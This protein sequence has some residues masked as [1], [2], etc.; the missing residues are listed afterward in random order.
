MNAR[1]AE[2]RGDIAARKAENARA[3]ETRLQNYSLVNG[4]PVLLKDCT[5]DQLTQLVAEARR[6]Q[7]SQSQPLA[8]LADIAKAFR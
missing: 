1:I 4:I 3:I 6:H 5:A 7:A 8:Y 2:G